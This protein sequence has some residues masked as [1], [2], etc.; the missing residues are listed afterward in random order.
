MGLQGLEGPGLESKAEAASAVSGFLVELPHLLMPLWESS[1]L[2]SLPVGLRVSDEL[3]QNR[4]GLPVNSS[5]KGQG[6]PSAS[7]E[8][9]PCAENPCSETIESVLWK[10]GVQRGPWCLSG[11]S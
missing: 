5:G 8:G 3:E 6:L 9:Y 7:E 10:E 1:F 11:M 2:P 4:R